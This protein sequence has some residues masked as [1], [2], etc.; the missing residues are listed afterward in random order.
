MMVAQSFFDTETQ[1]HR[2]FLDSLCL[3]VSV[4]RIS[5][6]LYGREKAKSY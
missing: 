3:C 4:S 5:I 6:K 2:V 1:K